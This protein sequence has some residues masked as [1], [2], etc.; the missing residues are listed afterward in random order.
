MRDKQETLGRG[1]ACSLLSNHC[2]WSDDESYSLQPSILLTLIF[3]PKY[4]RSHISF[5]Y[6]LWKKASSLARPRGD[7]LRLRVDSFNVNTTMLRSLHV[8]IN[9]IKSCKVVPSHYHGTTSRQS[10]PSNNEIRQQTNKPSACS[11]V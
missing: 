2:Y 10:D 11:H 8:K 9:Q 5:T 3:F 4:N 6:G 7:H 1:H